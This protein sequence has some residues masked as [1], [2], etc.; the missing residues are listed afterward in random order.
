[1]GHLHGVLLKPKLGMI[2]CRGYWPTWH[3]QNL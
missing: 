3:K 1:M 2:S